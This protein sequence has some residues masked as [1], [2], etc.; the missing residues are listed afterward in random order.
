MVPILFFIRVIDYLKVLDFART[1]YLG[2]YAFI[3]SM[4]D[5]SLQ[6]ITVIVIINATLLQ[7][8]MQLNLISKI[9]AYI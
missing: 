6:T 5:C 3:G 9:K 8:F 2:S 4:I 1:L 7:L